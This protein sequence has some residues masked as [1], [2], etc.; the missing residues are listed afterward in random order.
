MPTP[1]DGTSPADKHGLPETT[2]DGVRYYD[3]DRVD[4]VVAELDARLHR[5]ELAY[6]LADGETAVPGQ[7]VYFPVFNPETGDLKDVGSD[8]LTVQTHGEHA[9][10]DCFS[11]ESA[12]RDAVGSLHN[13]TRGSS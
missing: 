9:A 13:R 2:V 7:R 8:R 1:H 10:S 4:A 5:L 6:R 11:S 12:V 3:S